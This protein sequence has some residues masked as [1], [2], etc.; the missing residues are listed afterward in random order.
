MGEIIEFT[1][2]SKEDIKRIDEKFGKIIR[3]LRKTRGLSQEKLALQ[4]AIS[5][6][7]IQKY[8]SGKNRLSIGMF[9][10][11]C[12]ITGFSTNFALTLYDLSD[13]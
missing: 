11:I 3:Q 4:L 7:Q 9:Q 5:K 10:R 6:Q 2:Y 13:D 12:D 8:E 1:K